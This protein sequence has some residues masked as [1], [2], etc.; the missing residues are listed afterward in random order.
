LHH[1]AHVFKH[2]RDFLVLGLNIW[3]FIQIITSELKVILLLN[4]D[5]MSIKFVI[6]RN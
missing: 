2:S 6:T 3:Q 4:W 1:F 5:S